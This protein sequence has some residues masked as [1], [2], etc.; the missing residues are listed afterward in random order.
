MKKWKVLIFFIPLILCAVFFWQGL[1]ISP[2]WQDE[3]VF[4]RITSELP[5]TAT[6]D[7][8]F[9]VD[10]PKTTYNSEQ[11]DKSIDRQTYFARIYNT[12]IYVHI[13]LINYMMYPVVKLG[14]YLADQGIISHIEDNQSHEQNAETMAI[15]FR[16]IPLVLFI[17]TMWLVFLILE[18]KV[19][20]YVYL[21][22][23]PLLGSSAIL[24]AVPY[25]YWDIFMWFFMVLTLYLMERNSKWAY[26]TACLMVNTKI[27]IGLLLLIPFII[28]NRKMVFC[29]LSLIPFY[30]AT[31]FITHDIFWIFTHLG[32]TTGAYSWVYS[33]W[34][35]KYIWV[36]GLP[37][38]GILTLPILFYFKKYPVYA[39][40]YLITVIYGWGLG[41]TS[42]KM[43]GMLIS[44]T[45]VF[46]IWANE[47]KL[48]EKLGRFVNTKHEA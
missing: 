22:F 3:Y 21:Y 47:V 46:P 8:W 43:V 48:F 28:K 7:T 27:T 2:L 10:N 17:I 12:P 9:W 31:V 42:T 38:Y 30:L 26:L 11:W 5:S 41:I 20:N 1:H 25:F 15:G 44:G 6:S 24:S 34:D 14:N 4:Y 16:I 40:M 35:S 23:A 29:A 18:R 36:F 19:G 45:L 33:F 32:G 13:P 39:S 37:F